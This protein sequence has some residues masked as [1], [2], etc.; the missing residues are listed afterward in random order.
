MAAMDEIRI[1]GIEVWARHGATPDEKVRGQP[2]IVHVTLH[3]DLTAASETDDLAQT[4]DYGPLSGRIA[5]V[6]VAGPHDLLESVAGR[7]LDVVLDDERVVAAE[8]TIEKPHAPL[9]VPSDGVSVTMRRE[10]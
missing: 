5:E 2:F 3:L 9:P 1:R 4:V 7:V 8:V 10:R 6:A